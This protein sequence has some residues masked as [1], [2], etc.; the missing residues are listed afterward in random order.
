MGAQASLN[1]STDSPQSATDSSTESTTADT[2]GRADNSDDPYEFIKF[3]DVSSLKLIKAL[4][5]SISSPEEASKYIQAEEKRWD[6]DD[7][8]RILEARKQDILSDS[9][10][11]DWRL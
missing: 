4:A 6:R 7:V 1:G 8:V 10:D 3:L 2:G 5:G 11:H 9:P